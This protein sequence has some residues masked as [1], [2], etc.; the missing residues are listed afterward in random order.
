MTRQ[1]YGFAA[2]PTA[3]PDPGLALVQRRNCWRKHKKCYL[4]QL[5][6]GVLA[7]AR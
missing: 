1:F 7:F 4:V 6:P 2:H 3:K 5:N